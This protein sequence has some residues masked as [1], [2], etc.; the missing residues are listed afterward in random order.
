MNDYQELVKIYD[1]YD[2]WIP[3]TTE[4]EPWVVT[5]TSGKQVQLL[6]PLGAAVE[7]EEAGYDIKAGLV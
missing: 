4:R 2:P 3:V 6:I 1:I 7:I 5:L